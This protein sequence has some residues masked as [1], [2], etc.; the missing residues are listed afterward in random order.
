MQ[1]LFVLTDSTQIISLRARWPLAEFRVRRRN[2]SVDAV[3]A[4][5]KDHC[6]S[7]DC[8]VRRGNFPELAPRNRVGERLSDAQDCLPETA[9]EACLAPSRSPA[10]AML[11]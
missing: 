2:R 4:A 1:T 6:R 11:L 3:T 7:R 5:A 9:L 10:T 8:A